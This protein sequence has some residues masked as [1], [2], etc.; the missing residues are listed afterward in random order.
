MSGSVAE[1]PKAP[2]PPT[3]HATSWRKNRK[4][5]QWIAFWSVP[6]FFNLFGLVFVPLSWMMPPR[7]PSSS[8]PHIVDFMHSHNLLI[9]C[10]IL[11]L[12]YGLAPESNHCFLTLANTVQLTRA[13]R[14]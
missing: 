12:A 9:A 1:A 5:D 3:E 10:V 13:V 6:F 14:S 7:S 8:T 4:L 2:A 11:T